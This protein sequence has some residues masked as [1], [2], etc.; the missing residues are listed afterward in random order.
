MKT[1]I[2]YEKNTGNVSFTQSIG[3]AEDVEYESIIADI[4]DNRNVARVE[5]GI[6]ILD[7]T[8]EVKE[9][10]EKLKKL[11]EEVYKIKLQLTNEFQKYNFDMVEDN[12]DLAIAIGG[13]G[14]FLRMVNATNFNSDTYYVGIN[15]GTLGFLQEIKPDKLE[16][17]VKALNNNDFKIDNIGT[18]ETKI[19]TDDSISR[20]FSLN[21]IVIRQMELNAL[22]MEIYIDGC[23]LETF[24]G[25][26][27]L[28]ST[29]VGS[30]AYN[31]SFNG[32]LI[33]NT[34]HTLQI[35]PIAPLNTK[36]YRNLLTS[37]VLPE[38]KHILIKP[39]KKDLIVTFDGTNKRYENVKKIECSVKNKKI[40][41]LRM[42]EYNFI[43]IVNEKFLKD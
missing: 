17:F 19:T 29:S 22:T 20:H 28:V 7:D 37:I 2:V 27:I 11:N 36:A 43:N 4:P 34:L 35:T 33:Y 30:S 21:E 26:G 39:L 15:T 13:D 40:K 31:I 9:A 42:K 6:A 23:Y 38:K 8:K 5:N 24:A 18:L 32:S 16:S 14:S 10:K 12:Y 3:D 1:L 41:F 25:D